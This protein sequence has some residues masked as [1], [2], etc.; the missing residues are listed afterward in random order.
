MKVAPSANQIGT[1]YAFGT[2]LTTRPRPSQQELAGDA[3]VKASGGAGCRPSTLVG[4]NELI[5]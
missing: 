1:T 4:Q 5:A 3:T 2:V